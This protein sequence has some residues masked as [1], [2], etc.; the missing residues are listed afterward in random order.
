MHTKLHAGC[1]D[2]ALCASHGAWHGAV[3]EHLYT[4]E[5]LL[6]S[7]WQFTGRL[8]HLLAERPT[9]MTNMWCYFTDQCSRACAPQVRRPSNYD[10]STAIMLGP[11]LPDPTLDTSS[12]DI[13]RTVVEDS[14][15]KIF[16]GGLPADWGDEQVIGLA[17]LATATARISR[18]VGQHCPCFLSIALVAACTRTGILLQVLECAW[19]LEVGGVD[20]TLNGMGLHD[21]LQVKELLAPYGALRSFNLV[22]DKTTGKSKVSVQH[23]MW[24][25]A[26]LWC[27]YAL[28]QIQY[29]CG[30]YVPWFLRMQQPA[31]AVLMPKPHG[32]ASCWQQLAHCRRTCSARRATPSAS[33]WTR[34]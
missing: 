33:L 5:Q 10:A 3:R 34:A 31:A 14:W 4:C 28:V 30:A 23:C 24:N 2:E 7:T 11:V 12:L 20:Q 17:A 1:H 21:W 22:M 32:P 13:C 15:N 19:C 6:L 29:C 16:I 18:C 9:P 25:T 8:F 27:I 26:L